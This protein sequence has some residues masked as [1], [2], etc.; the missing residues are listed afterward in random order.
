MLAFYIL[1]FGSGEKIFF[2]VYGVK[3]YSRLPIMETL[4]LSLRLFFQEDFIYFSDMTLLKLNFELQIRIQTP[5]FNHHD[6]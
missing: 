6:Y 4:S 2:L 5:N 1:D 3:D